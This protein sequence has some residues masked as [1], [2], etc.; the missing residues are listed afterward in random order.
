MASKLHA[1]TGTS[2]DVILRD[3]REYGGG[4]HGWGRTARNL[5]IKPGSSEFHRLKQDR[6]N[7]MSGD[8]RGIRVREET[9]DD[10]YEQR[11][12]P[13]RGRGAMPGGGMHGGPGR[14]G[15]PGHGGAPP[16]HMKNRGR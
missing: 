6:H 7:T 11:G 12:G 2:I 13:G 15:P 3:Y 14:G 1:L 8:W 10:D 4:R 5:G 9:R 16:D